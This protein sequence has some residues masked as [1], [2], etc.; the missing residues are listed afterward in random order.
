[1]MIELSRKAARLFNKYRVSQ[2]KGWDWGLE[3]ISAKSE[4]DLS[5]EL[6][7]F[8]ADPYLMTPVQKHLAGEHDQSTHGRKG[9]AG[10]PKSFDAG[11]Y[12]RSTKF[13]GSANNP[14]GFDKAVSGLTSPDGSPL[15]PSIVTA[16]AN[17][18][19]YNSTS[20]AGIANV[21][22]SFD[23]LDQ[24]ANDFIKRQPVSVF[25]PEESVDDFLDS[26]IYL[27]VFNQD[28]SL[29]GED[30]LD[31]RTIYEKVAFGYGSDLE[32]N[33]RPVSGAVLPSGK[34]AANDGYLTNQYGS[35]QLVLNDNVKGRTTYSIGDSLDKFAK[36][37]QVDGKF[38]RVVGNANTA[39]SAYRYANNNEGQ[40][41]F[42]SMDF[43]SKN[44]LEA[45]VHGGV[46]LSDIS[47][48][49]LHFP[50]G[51]FDTGRLT[52]LGIPFEVNDG[53][54]SLEYGVGA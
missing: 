29:K 39:S 54:N 4:K 21:D 2:D 22:K 49:I 1:M 23:S 45:Q 28:P 46:K 44:Y 43:H 11:S 24:Q 36:P 19:E 48:V 12:D 52:Q 27:T 47:K 41:F 30:Y 26:E 8:L 33:E 15:D 40:N 38:P 37:T 10:F 20:V 34:E 14:S 25:M 18:A 42:D 9:G 6:Q 17:R 16:A 5:P 3:I 32:P 50:E 31:H 35:V 51:D 13:I 7:E 53:I